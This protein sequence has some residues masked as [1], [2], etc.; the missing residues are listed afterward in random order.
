VSLRPPRTPSSQE[1][2]GLKGWIV[3]NFLEENLLV[4]TP[5]PFEAFLGM[6]TQRHSVYG[7]WEICG[8]ESVVAGKKVLDVGTNCGA[9]ALLAA[10]CGAKS[11]TAIDQFPRYIHVV[12]ELAKMYGY[13]N[14]EARVQRFEDVNFEEEKYDV[15]IAFSVFNNVC[16]KS[17][18][19]ALKSLL[20]RI[21]K[22]T[23]VLFVENGVDDVKWVA[24]ETE[25]PQA[26]QESGFR[27]VELLGKTFAT[28]IGR[29]RYLWRCV[30]A[31][32]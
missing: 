10:I 7:R 22:C 26:L 17:G 11:V 15:I 3:N 16:A 27:S 29:D 24:W 13:E 20:G 9:D 32:A 31:R 4:Y 8:L 28:H 2:E 12:N 14:I 1:V 19:E 18:F 5:I 21:A 30:G 25:V 23:G 6:R